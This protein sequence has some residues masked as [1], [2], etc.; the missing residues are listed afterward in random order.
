M[1]VANQDQSIGVKV[2]MI[3]LLTEEVFRGKVLGLL[4]RLQIMLSKCQ[5][6]FITRSNRYRL[7][8]QEKVGEE[9]NE[10]N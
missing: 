2:A 9:K 10:E 5:R 3:I 1:A 7:Q 4:Y 6:M 8:P